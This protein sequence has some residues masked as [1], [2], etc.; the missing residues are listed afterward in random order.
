MTKYR[1]TDTLYSWYLLVQSKQWKQQNNMWNMFTFNKR[2][3]RT[4]SSIPEWRYRHRSD[5]FFVNLGMFWRFYC[6]L[7]ISKYWL[8]NHLLHKKPPQIADFFCWRFSHILSSNKNIT[9]TQIQGKEKVKVQFFSTILCNNLK[10]VL[11]ISW[12]FFITFSHFTKNEVFHKVFFQFLCSVGGIAW[13]LI[14]NWS[15]FFL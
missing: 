9:C 15:Q 7:W 5:V 14:K 2:D 6:W 1:Y 3:A 11:I 4:M 10:N 13:R 12:R 8:S